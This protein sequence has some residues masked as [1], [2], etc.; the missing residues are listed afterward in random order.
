MIK[1]AG[2]T[3]VIALVLSSSAFAAHPLITDD[4]GTQGR[5]NWQLEFIGEYG[6]DKEKGATEKGFQAPTVPFVSYGLSNAVDIVLG[7]PY[8]SINTK[9]AGNTTAVRG[10]TDASIE[11][12]ARF[13]EKNGLSL[14]FKPG[15]RLPTGNEEKGLGTGKVSY[16]AFVI[17]SRQVES[18]AFHFN[19]GYARNEYKLQ[20]DKEANRKDLWH[21][22]VAAEAEVAKNFKLVANV[23]MERNPDKTSNTHP[24]FGLGGFI[25]SVTEKIDLD[26]G[27][28]RGLNRAE[29]DY[30][31][32]AGIT[33]RL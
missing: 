8:E 5:G 7:L 17:A 12:K 29:T 14:A 18:W 11:V 3:A 31:L 22:S 13:Y 30:S 9:Q 1:K 32:L 26:L 19:V 16:N 6:I 28:K 4:A 21:I 2:A 27:I 20:A 15:V 25:Y 33:W 24:A 23:G 10:I